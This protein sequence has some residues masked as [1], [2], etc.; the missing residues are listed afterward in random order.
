MEIRRTT[1]EEIRNADTVDEIVA[2]YAEGALEG[3]PSNGPLWEFYQTLER[4]GGFYPIGAYMDGKL[5]GVLFYFIN[6]S[7]HYGSVICVIETIY[8]LPEYRKT[9]AGLKLLRFVEE[10]APGKGAVAMMATAPV[11]S[12]FSKVLT[13]LKYT[14]ASQFFYRCLKQE[15]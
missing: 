5:I 1:I 13:G 9:G 7:L 3:I 15:E 10:D 6:P 8:V 2:G 11:D 12:A 4:L 14:L